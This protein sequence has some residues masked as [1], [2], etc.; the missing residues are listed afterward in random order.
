[1]HVN[2]SFNKGGSIILEDSPNSH[3]FVCVLVQLFVSIEC[4]AAT[5]IRLLAFLGI[6]YLVAFL[7]THCPAL[8]GR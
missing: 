4:Q 6:E 3:F 8:Q 5:Q 1:M 7:S 2:K